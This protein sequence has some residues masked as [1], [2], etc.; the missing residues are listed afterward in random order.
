MHPND[1]ESKDE[2]IGFYK[3][4]S[5]WILWIYQEILVEFLTKI[6]GRR[7]DKKITKT[8]RNIEKNFKK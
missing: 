7:I 6:D 3:Y 5:S 8:Y 4:I 2:N 1:V